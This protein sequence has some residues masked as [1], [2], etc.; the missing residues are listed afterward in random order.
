MIALSRLNARALVIFSA[1]FVCCLNAAPIKADVVY[2]DTYRYAAVAYSTSTGEYGYA[3][4][5]GTLAGA[6]RA[7]LT[8]C[9]ADDAEIVGWVQ[10]GFIVLAIG[11]DNSYGIGW[12]Y[13]DGARLRDAAHTAETNCKSHGVRVVKLICLCSGNVAPQIIS[14]KS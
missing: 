4:D 8:N 14:A 12:E 2:F 7:A 3:Y 11:E 5:Y 10:G 1:L 13:G 9:S 6:K